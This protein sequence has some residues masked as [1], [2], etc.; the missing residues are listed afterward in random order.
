MAVGEGGFKVA[1]FG[2]FDKDEVNEYISNLRRKMQE[3]EA[4]KK[5][6]EDKAAQA[7]KSA[8]EEKSKID[9]LKAGY[10]ERITQ[11]EAQVKTER[12]KA[13]NVQIQCDELKRKL[14]QKGMESAGLIPSS[15]SANKQSAEIVGSAE[16]KARRIIA[17]A[18]NSA[19]D[20]VD[21]ANALA[22]EVVDKANATARA[23]VEKANVSAKATVEKAN[24][25][26]KDTVEKAN[27]AAREAIG[28]AK[29]AAESAST[30]GTAVKVDT[31]A[32]MGL[33]KST[34]STLSSSLNSEFGSMGEKIS[35]ILSNGKS[36]P[37]EPVKI[38]VPDFTEA[39][40][41]SASAETA[42][43]PESAVFEEAA[44]PVSDEPFFPETSSVSHENTPRNFA[45]TSVEN[46]EEDLASEVREV[47]PIDTSEHSKAAPDENFA[48]DLIANTVPSSSLGED[49]DE[50]LLNAVREKEQAFAVAPSDGRDDVRDFDMGSAKNNDEVPDDGTEAMKKML[51]E[52]EAAFGNL[53][54]KQPEEESE[55][56][57]TSSEGPS[58]DDWADLQKQLEA[59]DKAGNYG[60]APSENS[61]PDSISDD[62]SDMQMDA[63]VSDDP[64]APDAD[65]SSIWDFGSMD[66]SESTDDDMSSD[67]FG[68]I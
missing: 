64:K 7:L 43:V 53:A 47:E 68:K 8:E 34:L 44:A 58:N 63:D 39:F 55:D 25:T 19:K 21:K 10:E 38:E 27:A 57:S 32:V 13:D 31:E 50:D 40:V 36:E 23:T 20:V 1:A 41:P 52:A 12:R 18:N 6:A 62:T 42:D 61:A 16:E 2:G 35:G 28:K 29:Q 14:R 15:D 66:M 65:D 45:G 17:D 4:D 60:D 49:A 56:I 24:A 26:A 3:M 33:L 30:T 48:K 37:S 22:R 51:A 59:M 11:L 9:E 5:A 54:A 67:L 46:D